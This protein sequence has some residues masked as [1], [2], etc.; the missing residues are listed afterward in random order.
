MEKWK[1]YNEVSQGTRDIMDNLQ[2]QHDRSNI[3]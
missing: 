3:L 1:R 2:G